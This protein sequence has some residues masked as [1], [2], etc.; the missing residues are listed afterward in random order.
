MK[1]IVAISNEK[2]GKEKKER[3]SRES[4]T[5]KYVQIIYR[6]EV[7][8]WAPLSRLSVNGLILH[9]KLLNSWSRFSWLLYERVSHFRRWIEIGVRKIEIGAL[10]TPTEE[11]W[12]LRFSLLRFDSRVFFFFLLLPSFHVVVKNIHVF[13]R[14]NANWWNILDEI[15]RSITYFCL[16]EKCFLLSF[17]FV[18]NNINAYTVI[19]HFV[20][21]YLIP[22][23]RWLCSLIRVERILT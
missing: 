5:W 14:G 23:W 13:L 4:F 19:R 12:R 20:A 11:S 9:F 3:R 10:S 17:L 7:A 18:C 21:Y 15:K 2:E 8:S 22:C 1:S 6:Q 16:G